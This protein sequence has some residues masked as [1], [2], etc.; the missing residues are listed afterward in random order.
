[1]SSKKYIEKSKKKKKE[2]SQTSK[3]KII[4]GI[5]LI[6][7]AFF[8]SY[9]IYF[10]L[11]ASLGTDTPMVVVVSGSMEPNIHKGDLLFLTDKEP[12]DIK[13]GTIENK[14]GDVIVY[15]ARGLWAGAP[16][17]PIVHR[18][19]DQEH[20]E[21]GYFFLTK[22]DANFNVDK[23]WVP[24]ERVVGVV[25]GRIPYIGWVRIF[26]TEFNLFIPLLVIFG[27]LLIISIIWDIYQEKEEEKKETRDGDKIIIKKEEN[28]DY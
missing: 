2:K 17:E 16:D 4:I 13:V 10:G 9:I 15:D 25:C 12:E 6:F 26:L 18:V 20:N 3:K 19:V 23:A 28:E 8:G 7:F 22:G 14:E 21:S 11:Q 1:M 27:G 5:I 24:A